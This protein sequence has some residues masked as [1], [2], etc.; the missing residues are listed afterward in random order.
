MKQDH[1]IFTTLELAGCGWTPVDW[2]QSFYPADLPEDWRVSYYSNEFNCILLPIEDWLAADIGGWLADV[3]ESFRFYLEITRQSVQG[4]NGGQVCKA[5]QGSHAQWITALLVHADACDA[6]PVKC[7][8][9]IPVHILPAGHW[10]AAMPDGAEAQVG[11][12][13]SVQRYSPQILREMF[14]YLQQHTAHRD[15]TLFVDVSWQ[16]L[17]QLRLMQQ[18]YGV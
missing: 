10:L 14:E 2:R 6:L 9:A 15:V 8:E 12:I 11:V 17:E 13:R 1:P 4:D 16:M 5:L 18:V 7:V 3:P